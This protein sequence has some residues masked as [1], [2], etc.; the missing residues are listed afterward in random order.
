MS[1]RY[2]SMIKGYI[3]GCGFECKVKPDSFVASG[4]ADVYTKKH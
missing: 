4:I 2:E 1:S 3:T